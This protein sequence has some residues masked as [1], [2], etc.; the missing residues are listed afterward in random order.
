MEENLYSRKYIQGLKMGGIWKVRII[1]Y[2]NNSGFSVE[3]KR[4]CLLFDIYY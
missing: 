2:R 4:K 3:K 1:K